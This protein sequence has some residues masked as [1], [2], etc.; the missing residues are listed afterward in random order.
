[1]ARTSSSTATSGVADR[2][3]PADLVPE[4]RQRRSRGDTGR[5]S[6]RRPTARC[7]PRLADRS[8]PARPSRR[9]AAR[10]RSRPRRRTC[11]A[12]PAA[13]RDGARCTLATTVADGEEARP[14]PDEV[15]AL[16][17]GALAREEGARRIGRGVASSPSARPGEAGPGDPELLAEPAE[18]PDDVGVIAGPDR[19]RHRPGPS[20]RPVS[21]ASMRTGRAAG[22]RLRPRWR[23]RRCD[24]RA[25]GR[26]G[27]PSGAATSHSS[28]AVEQ[29]RRRAARDAWRRVATPGRR[30]G[31]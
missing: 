24:R 26:A 2:R 28:I 13:S 8:G 31:S 12:R 15:A 25:R 6:R 11:S 9:R 3:P 29:R 17:V 5:P 1:M 18:E 23:R 20:R 4:E 22:W 16:G 27:R 14:E 21:V 30:R 7:P 19:D 10:G